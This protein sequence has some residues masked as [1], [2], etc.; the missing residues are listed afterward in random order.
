MDN[1]LI[2]RLDRIENLLI[3][4]SKMLV[5]VNSN[6]YTASTII[7]QALKT[8]SEPWYTRKGR[9]KVDEINKSLKECLDKA[10]TENRK[11]IDGERTD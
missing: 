7:L 9:E 1:E 10:F 11:E 6:N 3:E 8:Y 5:L 4:I 2:E